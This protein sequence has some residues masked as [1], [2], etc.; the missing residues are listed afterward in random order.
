MTP[1]TRRLLST[2]SPLAAAAA[3]AA[4]AS[5]GDAPDVVAP[6]GGGAGTFGNPNVFFPVDPVTGAPLDATDAAS[7]RTPD[8]DN[9]DFDLIGVAAGYADRNGVMRGGEGV[10]VAILGSGVDDSHPDLEFAVAERY[11]IDTRPSAAFTDE[12]THIAGLVAAARTGELTNGPLDMHG[13]AFGADIID[14]KFSYDIDSN[15]SITTFYPDAGLAAGILSA[16]GVAG[17]FAGDQGDQ[18]T[19]TANVAAESDIIVIGVGSF[20]EDAVGRVE[21]AL[22]AAAQ[23]DK[24]IVIA[25]GQL[26][27]VTRSDVDGDGFAEVVSLSSPAMPAR[28]VGGL[29]ELQGN[30]IVAASLIENDE[31]NS[32]LERSTANPRAIPF[33][34]T[35]ACGGVAAYC[36]GAP[37]GGSLSTVS[38]GGYAS[39]D[40]SATAAAI[41]AGAAAVLKATFNGVTGAEIVDR[42]LSTA[43]HSVDGGA[44]AEFNDVEGRGLISL[45]RAL[46]PKGAVSIQPI[47]AVGEGLPAAASTWTAPAAFGAG[48]ANAALEGAVGF[49][50]DGFPF[51]VDLAGQVRTAPGAEVLSRVFFAGVPL[52]ARSGGVPGIARYS[53]ARADLAPADSFR[54]S[55]VEEPGARDEARVQGRAFVDL[56]GPI[57]VDVAMATSARLGFAGD[58]AAPSEQIAANP[59]R[60]PFAALMGEADGFAMI[61]DAP[62][63]FAVSA[64]FHQTTERYDLVGYESPVAAFQA[65]RQPQGEA[66][67]TSFALSRPLRVGPAAFKITGSYG[68]L[69]ETAAQLGGAGLGAFEAEGA[70]SD[71]V[72]AAVAG[73][74]FGFDLFA[75]YAVGRTEIADSM[76][77]QNWDGVETEA[78]VLGAARANVFGADRLSFSLSRPL[79][80][81]TGAA[82]V[83][84]PV[85]REFDGSVIIED[86][87]LDLQG[88]RPLIAEAGYAVALRGG[89]TASGSAFGASARDARGE[90]GGVLRLTR[91]L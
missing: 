78:F 60:E 28:L 21:Q 3:L 43:S 45:S 22:V 86:R 6:G 19:Y 1:V 24:I 59:A 74:A 73:A 85:G 68:R 82:T 33:G 2:A 64:A 4:C 66:R 40:A 20:L 16:A 76:L 89:W 46:E 26:G 62:K 37:G 81:R 47:E 75:S 15:G 56:P 42:I 67:M 30:V 10:R 18:P 7:W 70:T 17:S 29:T 52:N 32:A 61:L 50:E 31:F 39:S 8:Y 25:A 41:I 55:F 72:Q 54:R 80:A 38:G 48:F 83:A 90:I 84:L 63:G 5:S 79:T 58:V 87:A 69:E 44:T 65:E 11:D 13:V 91:A 14:I 34:D 77:V 49:D 57:A 36:V 53:I 88:D 27:G 51:P 12:T 71:Y 9:T 23:E 35:S